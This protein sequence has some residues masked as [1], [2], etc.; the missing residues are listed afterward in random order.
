MWA[1]G[2]VSS[3]ISTTCWCAWSSVWSLV[4]CVRTPTSN[5]TGMWRSDPYLL[6]LT[7]L[8]KRFCFC[9]RSD[10]EQGRIVVERRT[11][12]LD[13][14]V[15]MGWGY[16]RTRGTRYVR[17]SLIARRVEAFIGLYKTELIHRHGPWKGIDDVEY[18][19]LEWLAW[20]NHRRLLEPIG[21]IPPAEYEAAYWGL[22]TV[23]TLIE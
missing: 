13:R 17:P 3:R 22:R 5:D 10:V 1:C 7:V 12:Q 6:A 20:F 11:P 15:E 9:I 23:K 16:L 21:D 2:H 8:V 18:A 4:R 14:E 19:T